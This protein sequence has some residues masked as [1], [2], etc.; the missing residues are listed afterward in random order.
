MKDW[1]LFTPLGKFRHNYVS[2]HPK[3][4]LFITH[5]GLLSTIE[6]VVRGVPLIGI[7]LFADQF[8]T[9][10]RAKDLNLGVILD[11]Q[12]ITEGTI[13][14]AIIEVLNNKMWV[15]SFIV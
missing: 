1:N 12:N 6:T 15:I 10:K 7:P 13:T 3:T 5:G 14:A 9:M 11:Y 4:K 8:I 2:A